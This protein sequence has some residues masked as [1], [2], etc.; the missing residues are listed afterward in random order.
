M[1]NDNAIR[2]LESRYL[3]RNSQ[4][5]LTETPEQMFRR[6]A[7][8]ISRAELLYG[9]EKT[10]K[11]WEG[12][13]YEVMN[14]LY[15]LPNS[16][17]LMNA[18]LSLNQ[19]SACFVLPVN[20]SIEDIFNTL[21]HAALVQQSG[22]GTGFNFSK[23]RHHGDFIETTTGYSSGPLA[24]MKIYDAATENIKQGGKRRGANMGILNVDH[25]DIFD[26][27]N[28]KRKEGILRNF[29]ISVGISDAFMNALQNDGKWLLKD[30]NTREVVK[31]IKAR[32]IWD[33]LVENAWLSGDPG[34]VFLD[35]INAANPTPQI[36]RIDC[37]N[38]CGEVP[39][40]PYE[41]CN[42]GSIDLSKCYHE[43]TQGL[44][45]TQLS[46]IIKTAVR[47]LDN[48]IDMNSYVIPEIKHMVK[49]N[50]KIGLGV[51]GWADLL[52]RMEIPYASDTAVLLAGELMSFIQKEADAVS[53]SLAEERGV[54]AN[55][56]GSVFCP[57]KKMRNATRS[58]IAPTGTI[59][60]IA[61]TSSS[62]EPNYALAI[63]RQNVL[64]DEELFDI[65]AN[66]LH[67]LRKNRLDTQEVLDQL[68]ATGSLQGTN[69]PD[70]VKQLFLTALEIEPIWHLK[71]QI[72]FQKY[73]DNAVSKTIN[74]SN[75]ASKQDVANAYLMAW[76]Q[77]AKG[78][79]I[80]RDGCK[81]IQVLNS[82]I[83]ESDNQGSC[84]V[85]A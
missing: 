27:I 58:S 69:L 43:K 29:N 22:G 32:E 54:F 82:G 9:D 53:Q 37:T 26:F 50:R 78:I 42:L 83:G 7:H 33:A 70:E 17:T 14:D 51:M 48:V 25:P 13:F 75:D 73:T 52:I 10:A 68:K 57:H 23:L 47:F 76:Q 41:A 65:N 34:L 30:P 81:Q 24:F 19:L 39:L 72:A 44:D 28:L 40:L 79:T 12:K 64:N 63:R 80:Y 60:I 36:G 3:M 18:G 20:D 77:K 8:H 85:C 31:E 35:T 55:W 61:G 74:L 84:K 38:P 71:H 59:S 2:V 16:P 62:I 56:E 49:G 5:E 1:L 46:S 11:Y 15:F 67:Y 4:G 6:V 66:V 21:K 45:K